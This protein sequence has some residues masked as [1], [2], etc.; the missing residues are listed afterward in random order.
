MSG[1][2][3][4]VTSGRETAKGTAAESPPA[5]KCGATGAG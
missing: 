3:V 2:P 5:G 4:L 1:H